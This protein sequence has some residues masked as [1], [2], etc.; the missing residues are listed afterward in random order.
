MKKAVTLFSMFA[1]AFAGSALALDTESPGYV[2]NTDG[3]DATDCATDNIKVEQEPNG[4]GNGSSQLDTAYPFESKRADNF[5]GD[6]ETLVSV[7]WAGGY[8]NGAPNLGDFLIEIYASDG[9]CPPNAGGPVVF[10]NVPGAESNET[11]G[12]PYGYCYT[13]PEPWLAENGVDYHL[14]IQ[15]VVDFPPQW[16]WAFGDGDGQDGCFL[17]EFFN[18]G[19]GWQPNV[20]VGPSF[21]FREMAFTLYGEA[22]GTVPTED[23][24]WSSIK[25]LYR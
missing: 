19:Q 2:V 24:S 1:L 12:S 15:H 25:D 21:L 10:W 18:P 14:A 7:F 11:A 4:G 22:G 20:N 9:D 17:S 23:R 8:W 16:G 13:F 5:T 6:G 3:L